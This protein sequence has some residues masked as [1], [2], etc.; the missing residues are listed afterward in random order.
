MLQSLSFPARA[1]IIINPS[2]QGRLQ[3]GGGTWL[4]QGWLSELDGGGRERMGL[5]HK[6][7][8]LNEESH[9]PDSGC[10]S[11]VSGRGW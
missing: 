9:V 3:G 2:G 4:N 5:C 10:E 7:N 1:T 11:S 6:E 8:S